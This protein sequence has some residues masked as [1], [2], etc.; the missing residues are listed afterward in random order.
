MT[1]AL[2]EP[3][4][5]VPDEVWKM[6]RDE[7]GP[8]VGARFTVPGDPVPK[9]RR[10]GQGRSSVTPERTRK[11]EKRVREAF[12]QALPGWEPEPDLTY[13][14]LVEFRTKSGSLVD[15]DNAK[16]LI[17]DALNK[18]FWADDI[19]VGQLHD[20][21]VRGGGE[22]GVEVWLFAVAPNGTKPT[23]LCECGRRYRTDK[24][25]CADCLRRR[26][27]VNELLAGGDEAAEAADRLD[28]DRRAVYSFLVASMMG[29]NRSPSIAAI[30]RHLNGSRAVQVTDHRV[31]AVVDT[32]V[33]DGNVTR[34]ERGIK[35]VKPLGAPA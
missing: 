33:S 23:R 18:V 29:T 10:I 11:A 21:L 8:Y 6:L 20:R 5:P 27:I 13:G 14:A 22:P 34:T 19:Q 32:L 12:R 31:R 17:L 28:R 9:K 16:K 7:L 25:M 35:P 1:A 24:T 3:W 2:V 30:T 4:P 15:I 26:A